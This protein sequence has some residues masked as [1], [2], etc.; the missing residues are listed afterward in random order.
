MDLNRTLV[1]FAAVVFMS[2]FNLTERT[3]A[4]EAALNRASVVRMPLGGDKNIVAVRLYNKLGQPHA[5]LVGWGRFRDID[6]SADGRTLWVDGVRTPLPQVRDTVMIFNE[7]LDFRVIGNDNDFREVLR[8]LEM[9]S[10]QNSF[11]WK[12]VIAPEL[13]PLTDPHPAMPRAT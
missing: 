6:V 5:V 1:V 3:I 12:R 2:A 11:V 8:G 10:F 4:P 7:N 13:P 9:N